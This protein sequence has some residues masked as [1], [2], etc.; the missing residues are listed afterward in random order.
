MS[1]FLEKDSAEVEI[2]IDILIKVEICINI[3]TEVELCSRAIIKSYIK[4]Y[5]EATIKEVEDLKVIVLM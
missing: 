4:L 3:L 2:Q 5:L 1:A